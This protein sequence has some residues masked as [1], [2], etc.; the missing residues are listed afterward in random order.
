MDTVQAPSSKSLSHRMLLGAA[1]AHGESV[2]D[3]V[4]ESRDLECTRGV[5]E[6]AGVGMA[7]TSSHG[8]ACYTVQ[9]VGGL[10]RGGSTEPVSCDVH[11]SGTTCRLLT[12]LLASGQGLFAMHGVARL[13]ERPLEEL[14]RA[15]TALGAQFTCLEK[16]GHA[17]YILQA[18]GL[19]V[20]AL[21][22]GELELCLAE[23]SQYLSG[24]LLAAPQ[25]NG[26]VRIRLRGPMVSWPYVLLTLQ[27]MEAFGVPVQ[28]E[29]KSPNG[30]QP[31]AWNNPANRSLPLDFDPE[32]L[33]FT[34]QPAPYRAG[35]YVVE[36]DWSGASYLLAAGALGPQPVRVN[37]LRPDSLQGDAA[38]LSILRAM[39]ARVETEENA[40]TVYPSPLQGI[41]VNV[42]SC[43]DIAPTLAVLA[44]AASGTTRI[45][46]AAHLH[47]KECDRIAAPVAELAKAG[48][49]AEAREDGLLVYGM[50]L[51]SSSAF[52]FP[53]P[54]QLSSWGDHRI[55]MS[56]SLLERMGAEVHFDDP[57][58][59]TK[60][61]PH[62]WDTVLPLGMVKRS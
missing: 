44:A 36:G 16:P 17:P 8:S 59:V 46:G 2:V 15:L 20:D 45:F 50:G 40:V 43:P 14:L 6:A 54:L 27:V 30:W 38:M 61:F 24:L 31:Y 56:L 18:Q 33:R 42:A 49:R 26:P 55:A 4:L 9:G 51:T 3:Q 29:Q 57:D 11:E 21:P 48:I 53:H 37:N 1:L 22:E 52:S 58:V 62:F 28:V 47:Y 12:A 35:H 39:G 25:A 5:L 60:S 23:S 19:R 10:L 32:S 13:H 41:A 7:F 34:V